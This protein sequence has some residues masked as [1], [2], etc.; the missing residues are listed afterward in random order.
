MRKKTYKRQRTETSEKHDTKKKKNNYENNE[1]LIQ[2]CKYIRMYGYSDGK[3]VSLK[4]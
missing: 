1:D 2:A 3:V 4:S